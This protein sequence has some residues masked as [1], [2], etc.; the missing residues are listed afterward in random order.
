MCLDSWLPTALGGQCK[1]HGVFLYHHLIA[2]LQCFFLNIWFT[3]KRKKEQVMNEVAL[4]QLFAASH[5]CV[6]DKEEETVVCDNMANSRLRA[7]VAMCWLI[8]LPGGRCYGNH[9]SSRS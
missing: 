4:F 3:K 6:V 8:L 1:L 9:Y 5:Q 2:A 7:S